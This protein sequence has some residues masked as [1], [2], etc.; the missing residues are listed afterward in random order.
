MGSNGFVF[1]ILSVSG[2]CAFCV[3][4]G[5]YSINC[6][7]IFCWPGLYHCYF[8]SLWSFFGSALGCCSPLGCLDAGWSPI[9]GHLAFPSFTGLLFLSGGF[10]PSHNLSISLKCTKCCY[11]TMKIAFH[12]DT[13]KHTSLEHWVY[14]SNIEWQTNFKLWKLTKLREIFLL[15]IVTKDGI[16]LV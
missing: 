15:W 3:G 9:S 2:G 13:L 10:S 4:R 7:L 14:K 1:L 11:C 12:Y 8:C 16:E 6:Q 5:V